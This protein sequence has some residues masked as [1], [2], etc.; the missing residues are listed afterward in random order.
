MAAFPPFGSSGSVSSGLGTDPYQ[1]G[2]GSTYLTNAYDMLS[3]LLNTGQVQNLVAGGAMDQL[4]GATQ[5]ARDA[6]LGN[7]AR[8]GLTTTGAVPALESSLQQR[9]LQGAAGV[10]GQAAGTEASRQQDVLNAMLGIGGATSSQ[11]GA[12]TQGQLA[13]ERAAASGELA[14][15]AGTAGLVSGGIGL[16]N[17]IGKL[18]GVGSLLGNLWQQLGL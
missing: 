14:T 11:L 17:D 6:G 16:I 1:Y 9:Y 7:L 2:V 3:N 5:S 10:S 18:T 12:L 4:A 15:A 8:R 13:Q